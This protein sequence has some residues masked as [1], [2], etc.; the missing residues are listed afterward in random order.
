MKNAAS[1]LSLIISLI[2]FTVV[3]LAVSSKSI[4][5]DRNIYSS[6]DLKVGDV[7]VVNINDVSQM[8]F[9]VTVNSDDSFNITSN[10]DANVTGFLPK[11]SS[12]KKMTNADTTSMTGS[13]NM[14]VSVAATVTRKLKNGNYEIAG[15][16]EY[17]F[18]G[19]ASRFLISGVVDPAMV[20][21]RSA[22][23]SD[24]ANFRLEVRGLKEGAVS[25]K[26]EKL[27]EK[28]TAGVKLT[29]EEK[30]KIILDYLNKMINA[31][32]K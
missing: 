2:Y 9:S 18:N 16:R 6:S 31:L 5:K 24:I 11:V 28:E 1:W 4:W 22:Q 20:R 19:S 7:L 12:S 15:A 21:G 14:K 25:L 23:S 10:P 8:K 17:S 30:Q 27:A 29:E 26:R 32:T 13:G 3:P